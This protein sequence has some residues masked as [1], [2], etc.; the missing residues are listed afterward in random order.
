MGHDV[1][2]AGSPVL[3]E[4]EVHVWRVHL[5]VSGNE[6][7]R[8]TSRLSPGERR[9]ASRFKFDLDRRRYLSHRGALRWVLSEYLSVEPGQVR[10]D[11]DRRGK[12]CLAGESGAGLQFSVSHSG[13]LGLYALRRG[14]PVG[15]DVER[16][17]PG[18]E[19]VDVAS[20]AF[21][22]RELD[23][24]KA[25][26]DDQGLE[27]FFAIWT[28]KE[29]VAK[30]VGLGLRAELA[31]LEV[32]SALTSAGWTRCCLQAEGG[33]TE[34]SLVDLSLG[35]GFRGALALVGDRAEVLGL[36]C[37]A[38]DWTHADDMPDLLDASMHWSALDAPFTGDVRH[39]VNVAA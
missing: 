18:F 1:V 24:V 29:A 21:S 28:R 11:R 25:L 30:A 26:P 22:Q 14:I 9:R 35:P 4:H 6:L 27:A 13:S 7:E 5:D 32:P 36:E 8:R 33:R 3:G 15:V 19:W 2:L 31:S 12:P 38:A 39:S 17:A 16:T 37:A 34:S 23:Q 10:F 20:T